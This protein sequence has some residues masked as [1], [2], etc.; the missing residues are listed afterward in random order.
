MPTMPKSFGLETTVTSISP[1]EWKKL[2]KLMKK[3]PGHAAQEVLE[4]RGKVVDYIS[5]S[6]EDGVLCVNIGFKDKNASDSHT[7]G[8]RLRTLLTNRRE[9]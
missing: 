6:V 5:R 3:T 4:V 8:I 2:H 9:T 7:A 1:K